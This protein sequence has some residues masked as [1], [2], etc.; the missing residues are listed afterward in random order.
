MAWPS[1][2]QIARQTKQKLKS[3][4]EGS[5]GFAPNQKHT[6]LFDTRYAEDLGVVHRA[7]ASEYAMQ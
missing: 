6:R 7:E 1:F 4:L 3:H 2:G 5:F